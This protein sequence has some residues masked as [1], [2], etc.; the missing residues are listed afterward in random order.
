[1]KVKLEGKR[2]Y[3]YVGITKTNKFETA[4]Q[5]VGPDEGFCIYSSDPINMQPENRYSKSWNEEIFIPK[6]VTMVFDV[7][8]DEEIINNE[9]VKHLD[10]T[11]AL[12]QAGKLQVHDF[13]AKALYNREQTV[14]FEFKNVPTGFKQITILVKDK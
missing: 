9:T 8:S 7:P 13:K 11:I 2:E 4:V 10:T 1:M 12:I 5:F 6:S 3:P 14:D